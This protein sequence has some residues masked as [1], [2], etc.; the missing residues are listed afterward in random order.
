MMKGKNH[1]LLAALWFAAFPALLHADIWTDSGESRFSYTV[2]A[3]SKPV[4]VKPANVP[5]RIPRPTL[6]LSNDPFFLLPE[7]PE[8]PVGAL[9]RV[10]IPEPEPKPAVP[11][12]PKTRPAPEKPKVTRGGTTPENLALLPAEVQADVKRFNP[13]WSQ[14]L[15]YINKKELTLT[16]YDAQG[17][18]VVSYRCAAARNKGNKKRKGD[19]RTPEGSFTIQQIQPSETWGHDF[20]DGKGYIPY[21]YGNWFIRL[22]TGFSGIGIHGTHDPGSIGTRAT[23]GCIR[24]RNENLDSLKTLVRVGMAVII[25]QDE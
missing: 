6:D 22:R 23:E 9:H 25:G 2:S 5:L 8:V 14:G 24:L 11:A 1:R 17:S 20:G 15:I 4:E 12:K 18:Q 16:L 19:N 3:P 7:L 13:D 21:A 10:Q